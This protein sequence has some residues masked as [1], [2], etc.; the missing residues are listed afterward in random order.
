MSFWEWMFLL[1]SIPIWGPFVFYFVIIVGAF[2]GVGV[3]AVFVAIA[4]AIRR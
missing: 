2:I 4:E 3:M 1:C